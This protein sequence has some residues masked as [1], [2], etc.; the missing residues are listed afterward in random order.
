[1]RITAVRPLI[2]LVF[3]LAASICSAAAQQATPPPAANLGPQLKLMTP[4]FSDGG[5]I[6]MKYTCAAK[7][8]AVSPAI[9]WTDAPKETASFALILHDPDAHPNKGM[10]DVTHWMLW[11]VP[12]TAAQ[13]PEGVPANVKLEDGTLQGKNVRGANAY[14]GPCPPAGKPHHYTFEL[15][16]LDQKLDL[17]P[18]ATRADLLRAMDGHIIGKAVYIG[19]FHQ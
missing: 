8:S 2:T 13:L 17:A 10:S 9:Q 7:P 1:M 4:A 18:D 5:D 19:L 6:P 16:A 11:N 12:A 14:Q 3:L 15:Y